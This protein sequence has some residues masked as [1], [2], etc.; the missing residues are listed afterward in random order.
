MPTHE[1]LT[2]FPLKCWA[3]DGADPAGSPMKTLI[4]NGC[5]VEPSIK[6]EPETTPVH[7]RYSFEAFRFAKNGMTI[8]L[9][10]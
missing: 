9:L 6:R 1:E 7:S 4:V 2:L 3:T 8:R 10:S 5:D